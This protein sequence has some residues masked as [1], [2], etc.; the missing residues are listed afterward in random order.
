VTHYPVAFAQSRATLDWVR[1]GGIPSRA[2][3]GLRALLR[4]QS[5]WFDR[6]L[7]MQRRL[8]P[9]A[10]LQADPIFLLGAWRSGTTFL[11]ELLSSCPHFCFAQ[12]WQCMNASAFRL[13]PPPRSATMVVRPMDGFAVT[14]FTPQEDEFALLALGVP[15]VYR[16]FLDP[17]RLTSLT[18]LLSPD[19]WQAHSPGAWMD[20][21][22]EFLRGV[23]A[24][25]PERLVIKSPNHSYRIG[26]LVNAFPAASFI[27]PVRDPAQS[28]FS[29]LK[30]WRSMFVRYAL[31]DW[32][33]AT[34][35]SFLGEVLT[36]TASCLQR[37]CEL[38]PPNRLVVIDFD[39]LTQHPVETLKSACNRLSLGQWE[40]L[41]NHIA[42]AAMMKKD[43]IAEQY[44]GREL[45]DA[46][47]FP[48]TMLR[49]SSAKALSSHGI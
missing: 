12:T 20:T 19:H 2:G 24:G 36:A 18:E 42:Q 40:S 21:W 45:P 8:A 28:Y 11:H 49:S 10:A 34:L 43:Y 26:A 32:E 15:S 25:R 5:F 31:W 27:W 30:M 41:H 38:L 33:E 29:N 46:I 44:S 13:L 35:V 23:A 1:Q 9:A 39:A 16:G 7:A 6:N 48:A 3:F 47:Q 14:T 17:R 22:V 4:W 37:A